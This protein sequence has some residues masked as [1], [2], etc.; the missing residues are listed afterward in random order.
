M[1]GRG[2]H[3]FGMLERTVV[4]AH[5]CLREPIPELSLAAGYLNEAVEAHLHGKTELAGEL[6]RAADLP[7][8]TAWTESL[9]GRGGPWSRPFPIE[10]VPPAVPK[11]QRKARMPERAAMAAIVARDGFHCRF[12][13]IPVVRAEVR[14][15][16]NKLYPSAARWGSKNS[17]QHA[18]LQAL[19]LTFDHILPWSRGGSSEPENVVVACQPCNCGRAELTLEQVGVADPRERVPARTDWD[20]LERLLKQ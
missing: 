1:C 4:P 15:M 9:W 20:G 6:I 2:A 8:I 3:G 11:E 17:E 13:G 10:H 16:L 18:G 12:C 5:V 19:W 7:A 14:V